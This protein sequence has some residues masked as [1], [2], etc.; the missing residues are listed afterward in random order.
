MGLLHF[1]RLEHVLGFILLL[2]FVPNVD[3][4]VPLDPVLL[5]FELFSHF[6]LLNC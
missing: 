5:Q 6:L 3:F 4:D 1:L 2:H